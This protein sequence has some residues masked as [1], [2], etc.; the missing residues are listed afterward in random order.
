MKVACLT[1]TGS[2]INDDADV[3]DDDGEILLLMLC[4]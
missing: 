2:D 3:D 1:T 4:V